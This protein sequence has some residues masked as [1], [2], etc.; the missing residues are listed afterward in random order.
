MVQPLTDSQ[1]N[2]I[3]DLALDARSL[4]TREAQELLE[5]VYG[6]YTDG[7]L[8]PPDKLPQVQADPE[9]SE[10]YRRLAQFLDDESRAGM[11]RA[12]AVD[13]LV[14][15]IAFTHLNRL[16]AFKML[17][18]R[19]LIR[20]TVDKGTDSNGFKFYLADPEHAADLVLYER[21]DA[22]TAYRHFLLWQAG[23]VAQEVRVLFDP[24]TLPSRLFPRPRALHALLELLNR[25]ELAD[26]W[27][28]DETVGWVYQYF[29][30]PELQ[31]AFE[32][33]R[34][35]GA[36]FEAKDIPSAT[37]LFTPHWIVKFLVQNTLGRLWVE[38]HPDTDP[39]CPAGARARFR[40]QAPGVRAGAGRARAPQRHREHRGPLINLCALCVSV[41][42][43]LQQIAIYGIISL[44]NSHSF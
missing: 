5:G 16:V 18:A 24:D 29:N 11:A 7:R 21:G 2:L 22:D 42:I 34:T 26:A 14:K 4:L 9:T 13:K 43:S 37:Q 10:T 27:H 38:L 12:D 41:A 31:A 15:E 17:E 25:A 3:H 32:R 39:T 40:G 33:M 6:L 23:Q 19:G 1:C 44:W 28:A 30:E 36:K 20:G 8:D 35:S